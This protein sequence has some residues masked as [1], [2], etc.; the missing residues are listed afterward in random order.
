MAVPSTRKTFIKL[1]PIKLPNAKLPYPF[2]AAETLVDN[3]GK[4][5]PNATMV[6]E[7]IVAETLKRSA[8]T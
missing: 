6:A 8:V 7:I 4:L 1:A 3:S 2:L 5:V